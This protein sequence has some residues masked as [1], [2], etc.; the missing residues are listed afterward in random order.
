METIQEGVMYGAIDPRL[1]QEDRSWRSVWGEGTVYSIQTWVDCFSFSSSLNSK[2][3]R[4]HWYG[5]YNVLGNVG[6]G[7]TISGVRKYVYWLYQILCYFLINMFCISYAC[8]S[9]YMWGRAFYVYTCMWGSRLMSG[10]FF[11]M[12]SPLYTS[13][14][15]LLVSMGLAIWAILAANLLRGFTVS[16]SSGW[17]YRGCCICLGFTWFLGSKLLSSCLRG[18]HFTLWRSAP[19]T[20]LI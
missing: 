20:M 18:K 11:I 5:I 6:Y 3:Y 16:S 15:G 19:T 4:H 12:L 9:G 17:D 7:Q 14:Q 1:R 10:I 8:L 13:R 2:V